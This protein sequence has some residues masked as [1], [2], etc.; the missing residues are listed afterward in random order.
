MTTIV[1][2]KASDA[3]YLGAD[4]RITNGTEMIEASCS[5]IFKRLDW[6]MALGVCGSVRLINILRY[7]SLD[8]RRD[9]DDEETIYNF[10]VALREMFDA[11]DM[12]DNGDGIKSLELGHIGIV[13]N[14]EMYSLDQMLSILHYNC[15]FFSIGS[16]S[17]YAMGALTVLENKKIK[18][19]KVV[20][21]AILAAQRWD[22]LTNDAVEILRLEKK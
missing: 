9:D 5:K 13:Y 15:K 4:K 7:E 16:G 12:L 17:S 19:E 21:N 8:F 10:T 11:L 1:G 2:F 20:R 3:V 14:G 22:I 18:P 6:D